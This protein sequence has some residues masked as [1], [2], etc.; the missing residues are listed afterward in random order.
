[1]TDLPMDYRRIDKM[2]VQYNRFMLKYRDEYFPMIMP[3][4]E[5]ITAPADPEE[6]AII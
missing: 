4:G 1:M 5:L 3:C 6:A 2:A